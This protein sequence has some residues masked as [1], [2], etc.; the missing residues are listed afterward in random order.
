WPT[1]RS[2]GAGRCTCRRSSTASR[3]RFPSTAPTTASEPEENMTTLDDLLLQRLAEWRPDTTPA[4]LQVADPAAGWAAA[5]EAEAVDGVGCRLRELALTRSAPWAGDGLKDRA[6]KVAATVTG[7][8]EPLAL[9]E[10]DAP[11]GVAQLRSAAPRRKG[12]TLS[13]HE[14]TL[15]AD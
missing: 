9:V 12:D 5:L 11:R 6:A 7:L 13:Y 3:P 14:L 4:V 1:S 8:L 2:S 15:E 10:V